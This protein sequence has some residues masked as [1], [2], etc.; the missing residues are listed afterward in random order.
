[1]SAF[2]RRYNQID[3]VQ[4]NVIN[5]RNNDNSLPSTGFVA[6]Q[7]STLGLR[8]LP[9][10]YA[11]DTI[12]GLS[13]L[14]GNLSSVSTMTGF[15]VSTLSVVSTVTGLNTSTIAG[16]S[17]Y[18]GYNQSSLL[19]LSNSSST[20]IS[21]LNTLSTVVAANAASISTLSSLGAT[22]FS[23]IN[24]LSTVNQYNF[25]LASTLSSQVI[26]ALSSVN[27]VSTLTGVN[28]VGISSLS[29]AYG[30]LSVGTVSVADFQGLSTV[31]LAQS[32]QISS[33]A[34][35]TSTN[36]VAIST[37]SSGMI[38]L[39]S[40]VSTLIGT[41][42]SRSAFEGLSTTVLSQ[43]SQIANLGTS[44]CT[45][46]V[47]LSSLSSTV[48]SLSTVVGSGAGQVS[49]TSFQGLSTTVLTQ[50]SQIGVIWPS[51]C[52]NI[53]NLSSL[54]SYVIQL[55]TLA[56]TGSGGGGGTYATRT[57]FE[58][59]STTVLGQSSQLGNI[60][61]SLSGGIIN[62]SSLS[63]YVGALST[64][65]GGGFASL[66]DFQGL[67]TTVLAQSTTI[68]GLS[69][70]LSAG[71]ISLSTL[72]STV[73]TLSTIAGSTQYV[74]LPAFEGLSTT[75]LN[76]STQIG[77]I[78]SNVCTTIVQLSTLS[79]YVASLSTTFGVSTNVYVGNSSNLT[80]GVG[81][82][83]SAVGAAAGGANNVA[84]ASNATAI[85]ERNLASATA[86]AAFG[87]STTTLAD[88]AFTVGQYGVGRIASALTVAGGA[89]STSA[90]LM[91]A[92]S[93]QTSIYNLFGMTT[94]CNTV[95]PLGYFS[96]VGSAAIQSNIPVTTFGGSGY[97]MQSVDIRLTGYET[98][99]GA[100]GGNGIYFSR[101]Q[102]NAYWDNTV[103]RTLYICDASGTASN[104]TNRLSTLTRAVNKLN[105]T[106]AIT[107]T[108][109][110]STPSPGIGI[111]SLAVTAASSNTI[112]WLAQ[113][114]AGELLSA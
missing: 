13:D 105:G 107:A 101:Y 60:S 95:T 14:S 111:W 53:A 85:G 28:T 58:G 90:G 97:L 49:L 68:R 7:F 51:L 27:Q 38:S 84:S 64:S 108:V 33:L 112:N 20:S 82:S 43:S 24:T 44:L 56:G 109:F 22:L 39:S 102:F 37:L 98:P 71:I 9:V 75:V 91:V 47:Q 104:G 69:D 11:L 99:V 76:Q 106:P 48:L 65:I 42:V 10:T 21:T 87:F 30:I 5:V 15:G 55:S 74:L 114:N 32:S 88:A 78:G 70:S 110:S 1:M 25:E 77:T 79:S 72:S 63:S 19:G 73:L 16:Q 113:V 34:A 81:N 80:Y 93:A 57:E 4:L 46:I 8:M 50:S 12:P 29:T 54:S 67:S 103:S 41:Q 36:T 31:V 96:N 23:S 61:L 18:I 92:G 17:T 6:T 52:T 86:S 40:Y 35:A 59:L 45:T 83:A 3:N 89:L 2:P 94:A 100:V 26:V 66:T 62:L